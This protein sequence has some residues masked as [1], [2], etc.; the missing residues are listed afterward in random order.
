MLPHVMCHLSPVTS[1]MSKTKHSLNHH[2]T[3][4][5]DSEVTRLLKLREKNLSPVV[6]H[7][8]P[9]TC[10]LLYVTYNMS[11]LTSHLTTTRHS[12]FT[13]TPKTLHTYHLFYITCYMSPVTCHLSPV[14]CPCHIDTN[15]HSGFTITTK[16]Y[17]IL[18]KNSCQVMW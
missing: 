18:G 10:H 16:T 3:I 11:P 8:S 15:R 7:L 13:S 4:N 1:N 9:V 2:L 5:R 6:F 14:T 12:K 17:D